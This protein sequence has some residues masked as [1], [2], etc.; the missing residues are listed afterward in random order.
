[1]TSNFCSPTLL[2]FYQPTKFQSTPCS[3]TGVTNLFAI[4]GHSLCQ[5]P[6]SKRSAQLFSHTVKPVKNKK[7]VNQWKPKGLNS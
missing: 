1:M 2:F 3:K 5:L 6:L 7:V 4:V